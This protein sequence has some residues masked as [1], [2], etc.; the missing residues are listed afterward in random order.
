MTL[1]SFL[2]SCSCLWEVFTFFSIVGS[3]SKSI[4][5]VT[6]IFSKTKTLMIKKRLKKFSGTYEII[7]F[8]CLKCKGLNSFSFVKQFFTQIS[9]NIPKKSG[10]VLKENYFY[11]EPLF[12]FTVWLCFTMIFVYL[13]ERNLCS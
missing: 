2:F 4:L 5:P 6:F 13:K 1:Q 3:F 7:I 10:G 11:L 12:Y 9:H 8:Q